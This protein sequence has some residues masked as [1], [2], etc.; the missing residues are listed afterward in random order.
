M[1]RIGSLLTPPGPLGPSPLVT[2]AARGGGR[3]G[4]GGDAQAAPRPP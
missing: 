1:K 4:A 2:L 3:T